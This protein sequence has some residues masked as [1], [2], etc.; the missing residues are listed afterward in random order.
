MTTTAARLT[1]LRDKVFAGTRLT[2][3]DGLFL[4]Q[5]ADLF[6]LGAKQSAA[7]QSIQENCPLA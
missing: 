4:D 7:C 2:A 3:D 5:H 6:T 1:D